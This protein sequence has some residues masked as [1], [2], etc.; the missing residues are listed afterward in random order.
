MIKILVTGANG[1][2]GKSFLKELSKEGNLLFS[3]SRTCGDY[4][5]SLQEEIPDFKESFNLVI[6]AAGKAHSVPKTEIEKEQ[7]YNTNVIGT[8]NLLKGLE[9]FILPK[10][11]VFISSVSVYGQET[12]SNI[13]ED[14]PL[15]AQDSYGL[16]KIQAEQ[17]IVDWCRV[18]KITCTILRLPLLVGKKP[19]GN[20]GAMIKALRKSYYFNIGKGEARKSMVLCKDVALLIPVVSKV[21][22]I[23]NLTDGFHPSFFELSKALSNNKKH[24]SLPL[25]W[26]KAL[27][28]IGDFLGDK[29]PINSLRIKKI[30]SD[31]I[32]DDSKARKLLNWKPELVL[33]Y[34]KKENLD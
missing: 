5:V 9:K 26:A 31:L 19:P 30:T 13:S 4:K 29:A 10:E 1:F 34:I 32:F 8:A 20:L 16:S 17:L 24:L 22:G 23:Y 7:F 27:G 15:L 11:F 33:D 18:N 25:F 21:G 12:G 14:H 3:L 6:H 28:R 2:L